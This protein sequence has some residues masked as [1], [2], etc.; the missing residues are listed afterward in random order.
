MAAESSQ[1]G[2]AAE[3]RVCA[4]RNRKNPRLETLCKVQWVDRS[5]TSDPRARLKNMH[6]SGLDAHCTGSYGNN[7]QKNSLCVFLGVIER[8]FWLILT[9]LH[10]LQIQTQKD[11]SLS[12][13]YIYRYIY[14]YLSPSPAP[15]LYLSI[16]LCQHSDCLSNIFRWN[17]H[18]KGFPSTYIKT[19]NGLWPHSTTVRK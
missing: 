16:Y 5:G 15:P 14:L 8:H 6:P 10:Y 1:P 7:E 12:L 9:A 19:E 11:P 18:R 2:P 13:R 4:L 17:S 3:R